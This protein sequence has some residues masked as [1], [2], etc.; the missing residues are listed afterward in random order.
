[1]SN[2]VHVLCF[3]DVLCGYCYAGD[4]RFEEL[5][6]TFGDEIAMSYHFIPVYGDVK[7]RIARSSMTPAEYGSMVRRIGGQF[8]HV[9]FAEGVF[10][11]VLPASSTAAHLYLCA[12][13]LLQDQGEVEPGAFERLLWRTRTA[14][15]KDKIDV[16]RRANLD[17]LAEQSG[18]P[19]AE[20]HAGIEDGRAFAELSRDL[21]LQRQYDV[22]VTPS[23]VMNEGRQHLNGNVGYRV[24][25]A[26][27]RE[28]LRNP[29]PTMSWC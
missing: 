4:I 21:E 24:L 16:S 10:D 8:E 1:M 23:L 3:N 17:T 25:E 14:F 2:P 28:L 29:H 15:F 20:V 6:T 19:I 27:V 13:R 9:E 11:E 12:V 18:I 7:R 5:K 22:R 26:N